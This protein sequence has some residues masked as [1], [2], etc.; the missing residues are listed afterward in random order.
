MQ[1]LAAWCLLSTEALDVVVVRRLVVERV[2]EEHGVLVVVELDEARVGGLVL[3]RHPVGLLLEVGV[4]E[5]VRELRALLHDGLEKLVLVPERVRNVLDALPDARLSEGG[6]LVVLLRVLDDHLAVGRD[7]VRVGSVGSVA[8]ER[9]DVNEVI[10]RVV[11]GELI[12]EG[13]WLR[14]RVLPEDVLVTLLVEVG[15]GELPRVDV[16]VRRRAGGAPPVPA[17]G[18]LVEEAENN[19]DGLSVVES[20]IVHELRDGV[21]PR[22]PGVVEVAAREELGHEVIVVAAGHVVRIAAKRVGREP[23]EG[24]DATLLGRPL[25]VLLELVALEEVLD[26][27]AEHERVVTGV[28]IHVGVVVLAPVLEPGPVLADIV[29]VLLAEGHGVDFVHLVEGL[30]QRGGGLGRLEDRLRA[31]TVVAPPAV[32][33]R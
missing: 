11:V 33:A 12:G 22:L 26:I 1:R 32:R 19:R 27:V 8:V 4:G 18:A 21:E 31:R 10:A 23:A 7:V 24:D 13:R 29:G 14:R 28:R 15:G 5:R 17:R 30:Q 3:H 25:D 2:V 16:R 9:D 20:E 6:D